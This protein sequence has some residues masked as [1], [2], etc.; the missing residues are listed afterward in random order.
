MRLDLRIAIPAAL[1]AGALALPAGSLADPPPDH[2]FCPNSTD[3]NSMWV[4]TSTVIAPAGSSK[5]NNGDTIVCQKVNNGGNT[6]IKDNNNPP[7]P[8]PNADD[9]TDNILG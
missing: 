1:A 4:P 2:I 5:D 3:P 6:S 8:S 9:Y 7:P